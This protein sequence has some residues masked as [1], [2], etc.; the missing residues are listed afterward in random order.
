M[1]AILHLMHVCMYVYVLSGG[2]SQEEATR[3]SAHESFDVSRHLQRPYSAMKTGVMQELCTPQSDENHWFSCP[4]LTKSCTN[5]HPSNSMHFW[6]VFI[7]FQNSEIQGS[8]G[9][10]N[11]GCPKKSIYCLIIKKT[12]SLCQNFKRFSF[13]LENT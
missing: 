13:L 6:I 1:T 3:R 5:Y 9:D 11:A 7:F 2:R 12:K 10:S 8:R 4:I